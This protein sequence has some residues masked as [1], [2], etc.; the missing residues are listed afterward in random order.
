VGIGRGAF[1][2]IRTHAKRVPVA[3]HAT[4]FAH[5]TH[6]VDAHARGAVVMSSFGRVPARPGALP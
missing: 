2:R 5:R 4:A 6:A 1:P 3:P